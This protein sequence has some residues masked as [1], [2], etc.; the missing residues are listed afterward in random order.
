MG[1]FCSPWLAANHVRTVTAIG[2]PA[3]LL[4]A[5]SRD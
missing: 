3:C 2:A 1:D 4:L 5:L